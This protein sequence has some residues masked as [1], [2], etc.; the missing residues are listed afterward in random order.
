VSALGWRLEWR[1]AAAR[2]RLFVLNVAI[3]LLLVVPVATAGAPPHH[4]AAVFAVLFVL[5]GTFGAAVPLLRDAERGLVRRLALTRVSRAGLLV[6]RAA[7]GACLDALQLAPAALVATWGAPARGIAL[8]AVVL[9]ATLLFAN[10]FGTWIAALARSVAEGALFCAVGALLLLHASGVF[11]T[12]VPG[13]AGEAVE[14]LAPYRAL[15]E[16]LLAL[17]G[18]AAP[19]GYGALAAALVLLGALTFVAAP[20]LVRALAS[21]DGRG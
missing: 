11:R 5:F 17:A 7:A 19:R 18:S 3:P 13:S 12:P 9:P 1:T 6:G 21:A 4:A 2:R 15:H 16:Q 8:L 10:L 14:R 20:R